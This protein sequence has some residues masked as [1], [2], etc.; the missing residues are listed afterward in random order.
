VLVRLC[1]A[2]NYGEVQNLEIRN[3]DPVFNPPPLVLVALK[4]EADTIGRDEVELAD[5]DL[6]DE[7]CRFMMKLDELRD[8][9]IRRIE[10]H[11]GTPRRIVYQCQ[12]FEARP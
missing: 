8:T 1:Q 5:F 10:V 9:T 2:I 12:P 7:V 6:R 11:A 3:S 4:L